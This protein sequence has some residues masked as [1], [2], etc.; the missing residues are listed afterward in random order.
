MLFALSDDMVGQHMLM[1]RVVFVDQ[2]TGIHDGWIQI[3]EAWC[4]IKKAYV[5]TVIYWYVVFVW[6]PFGLYT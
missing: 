6:A 2:N 5:Y 3:I 4:V 1:W